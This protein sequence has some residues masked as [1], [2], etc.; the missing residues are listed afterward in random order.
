MVTILRKQIVEVCRHK[1]AVAQLLNEVDCLVTRRVSKVEASKIHAD[2]SI[3]RPSGFCQLE[4]VFMFHENNLEYFKGPYS[5]SR[6]LT[7]LYGSVCSNIE[8]RLLNMVDQI[9]DEEVKAK[10]KGGFQSYKKALMVPL[11]CAAA[12]YIPKL[13][14]IEYPIIELGKKMAAALGMQMS[15]YDRL[16]STHLYLVG[17]SSDFAGLGPIKGSTLHLLSQSKEA[18]LTG[19]HMHPLRLQPISDD[20]VTQ[21]IDQLTD[22]LML[23]ARNIAADPRSSTPGEEYYLHW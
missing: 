11:G 4:T 20:Q 8:A 19:V 9:E 2:Y 1:E 18:I 21:L 7:G 22:K 14:L 16:S 5:D 13:T 3:A 10:V 23:T 17:H 15:V 6:N 12:T